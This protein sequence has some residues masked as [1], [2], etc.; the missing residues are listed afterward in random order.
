MSD[1]VLRDIAGTGVVSAR[2]TNAATR[3]EFDEDIQGSSAIWRSSSLP[4]GLA[5]C[6]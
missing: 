5:R 4:L 3:E 1:D 6:T 2:L